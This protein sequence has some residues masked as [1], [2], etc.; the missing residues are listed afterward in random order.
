MHRKLTA[1]VAA[2]CLITGV[3]SGLAGDK[4]AKGKDKK[5]PTKQTMT[6]APDFSL[7]D[8]HGKTH[9]LKDMKGKIVVLE[10]SNKDCPIWRAKMDELA[11]ACKAT[12]KMK[13][14][15][16]LQI[17][18]TYAMKVDDVRSFMDK[19]EIKRPLLLDQNGKVGHAYDARTTPH[20]FIIDT[21]GHIA[22]DGAIDNKKAGKEHVNYVT[23]ALHELLAGKPVTEPK[24]NPY[25][26]SVK[27]KK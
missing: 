9:A 6:A 5:A 10:W 14:V 22:Y 17:D 19:H 7:K 27:Y 2:A 15:V 25:G 3:S 21:H 24:T 13:D 11:S 16:W 20:M 8:L 4:P 18:S 12:A 26:C 23:K 1:L